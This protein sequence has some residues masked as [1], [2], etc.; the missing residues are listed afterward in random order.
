VGRFVT[1]KEHFQQMVAVM[2]DHLARLAATPPET[3]Q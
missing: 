2:Q 3:V 1:T